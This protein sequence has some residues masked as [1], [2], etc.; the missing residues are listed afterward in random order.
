MLLMMLIITDAQ[1][2]Q[3]LLMVPELFLE[4]LKV[5]SEY[6]KFPNKLKLCRP[7]LRNIEVESGP[8]KLVK[9]I[10]KLYQLVVMVHVLSGILNLI[11]DFYVCLNQQLSSK[12]F[13]TLKS[14]KFWLLVQIEKSLIGKSMME[15]LLDQS[16]LLINN[17]ILSI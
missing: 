11:L 3:Q 5:K 1:L 16:K 6:G 17:W 9:I 13:L 14:I 15:L 8:F 7:H 2:L 12:P 4:V 10:L